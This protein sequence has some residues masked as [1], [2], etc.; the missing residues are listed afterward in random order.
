MKKI[1]FLAFFL[2]LIV[3]CTSIII[4]KSPT[5]IGTEKESP[6][7]EPEIIA[8]NQKSCATDTDCAC[9]KNKLTEECFYGNKNYVDVSKQCPDFCTGIAGF[10]EIKCVEKECRQMKRESS[11]ECSIDS[12]C[13]QNSCCHSKGC[14]PKEKS[15]NCEGMMC[16]LECAPGTLDCGGY[17]QCSAGKCSAVLS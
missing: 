14:V 5:E 4:R 15:P 17:C 8:E 12:D 11:A 13:V 1:V 6:P 3:G 16:T 7:L 10:F 9:G 2:V